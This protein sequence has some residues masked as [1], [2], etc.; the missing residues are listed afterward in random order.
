ML[1]DALLYIGAGIIFLWG[2]AHIVVL[3]PVV[4]G[5]GPLSAQNSLII[6]MEWI[7]EGLSLCF[8]GA[9]AALTTTV[10]PPPEHATLIYRSLAV[11]LIVL[12]VLSAMTGARTSIVPMKLCPFVKSS[13]AVLFVL[14]TVV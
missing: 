6:T 10:G 11:F 5:F 2:L 1:N 14:A 9:L 8:V 12:A 7:A 13:V 4:S 3:K